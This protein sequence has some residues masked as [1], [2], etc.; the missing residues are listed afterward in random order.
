[1]FLVF[2]D[3]LIW[4][5]LSPTPLASIFPLRDLNTHLVISNLLIFYS[6]G[7]LE[8]LVLLPLLDPFKLLLPLTPLKPLIYL[9]FLITVF[10]ILNPDPYSQTFSFSSTMILDTYIGFSSL[11]ALLDPL[12]PLNYL[13]HRSTLISFLWSSCCSYY[14]LFIFLIS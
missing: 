9:A 14:C 4:I 13:F 8:L 3:F 7:P 10:Q 12:I 1:M 5:P 2:L 11:L 6:L